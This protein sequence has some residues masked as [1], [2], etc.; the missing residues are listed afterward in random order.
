M[1]NSSKYPIIQLDP[2]KLE[3]GP[4]GILFILRHAGLPDVQCILEVPVFEI[5]RR[6]RSDFIYKGITGE[7][8]LRGNGR[9]ITLYYTSYGEP[10]LELTVSLRHY[11]GSPILRM[12]YCLK[13]I[14]NV[15]LTKITGKDNILYFRLKAQGI[16]EAALTEY[17]LSHFDPV[18]HTY[19]PNVEK[20]STAE[21]R[22]GLSFT[23]PVALFHTPQTTLLAAYEH[24]ADHPDGFFTFE[25]PDS[26]PDPQ[27]ILRARKGNYYAGQPIGPEKPWESVWLELGLSPTPLESFLPRYRN[28]FLNEICQNQQ[29]RQP[30]IFYNTWNFQERNRYF[31]GRPY[32]ESMNYDRMMAE[33][34]VAHQLGIDVFV[35]DTGWYIKTGDWQVN[36]QRFPDGLREIKR[37][38]DGYGMKLGLWFNPTVAALTSKI[39]LEHPE[40][41]MTY[42]G[43]PR[44]RGPI[45]ETEESTTMCLASGYAEAFIETMVRLYHELG[46]T[47]FKWDAISQYGCDSPFHDHGTAANS[48]EERWECYGYQMGLQMI[49]IVEEVSRRCP[50]V[51]VDFDITEGGRFVGL[52]FLS[53]GK[54]FLINNGPYFSDFDIPNWVKMEPNT[55]NVFFYAGAARPRI[56]RKG[57][58]FDGLIPSILFLTHYLPDPPAFSQRNSLASLVLGGNGIWGDLVSLRE[59]DIHLLSTCIADYKRVAQAV[60][61]AYP[62][63]HGFP[64]S[65][66]EIHEKIEPN[67]ANGLIAFFT[68]APGEYT[69]L[70]QPLAVDKLVEVKSAE[71][72]EITPDRRLRIR[73]KLEKDDAR[74]VYLFG[75]MTA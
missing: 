65:S 24:G 46:V 7:T 36:R 68:V 74:I 52:G 59:E 22:N 20:Y 63:V 41:V 3:A 75:L 69:Y 30:Y 25:V 10:P 70:T 4:E 13:S 45:W 72:W 57:Y 42:Q 61:H 73:V 15:E 17:Q 9:E 1:K 43:Q 5:N 27:L 34:E 60:T 33:I 49:R 2:L 11:P 37:K 71:A 38:L 67:S 44:W 29:S 51:I 18:A 21:L 32:L 56:C 8:A 48:A 62:R 14:P 58:A 35:I 66:P 23:G 12:R 19:Q 39:Y 16:T 47:Y 31:N 26:T 54:Y 53:V 6:V 28:F 64:G 55:I 40:Y 50:E